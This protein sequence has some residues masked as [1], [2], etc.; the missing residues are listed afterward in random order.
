MEPARGRTECVSFNPKSMKGISF[1]ASQA[2]EHQRKHGFVVPNTKC[3]QISSGIVLPK[4][5]QNATEREYGLILE[6]QKRRGEIVDYRPFGIKL[7]WGGDPVTGKPMVYSPDFVIFGNAMRLENTEY[8][9]ISLIEVKG[10]YIHP[11]DWIRF[12]GCRA[13]WPMFR[14][15]LHQK[16]KEGWRHLL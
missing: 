2:E 7:E 5:R 3:G 9:H 16:T 4:P 13:E 12:K 6:A 10:G 8:Q 15:E 11:Q 14:F 1:S